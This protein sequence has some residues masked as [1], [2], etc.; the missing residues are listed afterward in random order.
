MTV[1]KIAKIVLTAKAG[2]PGFVGGGNSS[3]RQVCR[4]ISRWTKTSGIIHTRM[5]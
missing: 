2:Q 5:I 1:K 3:T 4:D